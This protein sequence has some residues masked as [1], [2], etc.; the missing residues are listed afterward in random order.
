MFITL[1]KIVFELI[2]GRFSSGLATMNDYTLY[3]Y[4]GRP[5]RVCVFVCVCKTAASF[6]SLHLRICALAI[7]VRCDGNE[8]ASHWL[9]E[10][11][12]VIHSLPTAVKATSRKKT[13]CMHGK[14]NDILSAA[15]LHC[16]L[17]YFILLVSCRSSP[18]HIS[19]CCELLPAPSR[20]FVTMRAKRIK[21]SV[22]K[23]LQWKYF[24]PRSPQISV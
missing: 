24:R 15:S 19:F 9:P 6:H 11:R 14:H 4:S 23:H 18:L 5:A 21:K 17:Q 2:G 20:G 3:N 16:L 8:V 22:P 7:M 13:H 10:A 12:N 1:I